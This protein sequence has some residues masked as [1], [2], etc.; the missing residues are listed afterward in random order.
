MY[1]PINNVGGT[2]VTGVQTVRDW[3]ASFDVQMGPDGLT[4]VTPDDKR[5]ADVAIP[6]RLREWLVGV[7]LLRHVPLAYLV[8]DAALLP[9]ESVRCFH[10]D[11]NWTERVIDGVF[12]AAST[13]TVASSFHVAMLRGVR[14][15]LDT[16][17]GDLAKEQ[18]PQTTWDAAASVMT[19][20]LIRSE[21]VRRWPDLIVTAY[22]GTNAGT[23][24]VPVLRAEPISRD[25]Y[26]VVFAGAPKLVHVREPHA[27]VRFGVEPKSDVVPGPPY[28]VDK[29]KADGTDAGGGIDVVL[30]G[31]NAADQ[32][33]RVIAVEQ[34]A[35]AL[36]H[37]GAN[38]N[39]ARHV[40]LH[41][42]QRPY[43]Q[44]FTFATPEPDG[45][46]PLPTSGNDYAATVKLRNNRVM[47]MRHLIARQE[48][49]DALQG[50]Q[51]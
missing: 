1:R 20:M 7:R 12:A 23:A 25:V 19:G 22:A 49:Q 13:G 38:S 32:A 33:L 14:A 10:V 39:A 31:A 48:Q 24:P 35:G 50:D 44:Q 21:L 42:E 26:I 8:P 4:V 34:F 30:R 27:G 41:L 37:L 40:A 18:H 9:A 16:A 43:V 28:K 29:R 17:L 6:E 36:G 46:R 5:V 11:P 3:V 45:S 2:L 47:R 15:A 51:D